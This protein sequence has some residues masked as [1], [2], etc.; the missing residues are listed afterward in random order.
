[1]ADSVESR[2]RRT[3]LVA[4]KTKE[5]DIEVEIDLD[6]TGKQ[7]IESGIGFLD[8]MF[9]AMSK[10]GRFDLRLRCKGDLHIDDHH[11]AEDCALALGQAFDKALG[12][13][14]DI[15]R[16]GHAYCPLDEALSRAVVDIS[17]RPSAHIELG[18]VNP[19]VMESFATEARI[20]LHVDCIKGKVDHHKAESAFKALGVA[21]RQ[22][23][24]YDANAGVPS[25]KG[26]LA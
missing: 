7:D 22:A 13:R 11:T 12:D 25:T 20:T 9:S 10:H 8:H 19:A 16:F 17:S 18:L 14:K 15:R 26:V 1:M 2:P 4:R 3:A 6:G 21:L 23:V 5:T 24:S